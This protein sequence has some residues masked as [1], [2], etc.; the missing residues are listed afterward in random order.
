L[1]V[2]INTIFYHIADETDNKGMTKS[3]IPE[4]QLDTQPLEDL[5][6]DGIDVSIDSWI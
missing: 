3:E 4:T 1:W 6:D 2:I 5:D